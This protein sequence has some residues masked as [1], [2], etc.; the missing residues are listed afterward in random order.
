[1]RAACTQYGF[2]DGKAFAALISRF[3]ST[4]LDF[5]A[6]KD[7]VTPKQSTLTCAIAVMR[8]SELMVI[9]EK[10]KPGTRGSSAAGV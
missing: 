8:E 3:D 7:K 4:L 5:E 10:Q 1:V 9:N 2:Q 6:V